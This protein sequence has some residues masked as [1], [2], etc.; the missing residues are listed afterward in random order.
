M[1]VRDLNFVL[2]SKFFVHWDEQLRVS[3]LNLRVDLVYSTWQAFS[4][5]LLVD[6]PL[7]SYIDVRHVNFLPPKFTV[8]EAHDLGLQYTCLDELAPI[9]DESTERVSQR[10]REQGQELVQ[11]EAPLQL[12]V[13]VEPEAPFKPE[14]P[15]QVKEA[16]VEFVSSLENE[17][18]MVTR[19]VMTISRFV[20]V[21]DPPHSSKNHKVRVKLLPL[22]LLL[23]LLPAFGKCSVRPN[24]L[25]LAR[26]THQPEPLPSHQ[27]TLSSKSQ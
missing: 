11:Q 6:S 13:E 1:H 27:G 8:G 15:I 20:P 3:H 24:S 9:R 4:H 7:L 5:A 26:V 25:R 14:A 22:L 16:T 19:K 2:R 10:R 18:D 21:P 17:S 12:K 23:L